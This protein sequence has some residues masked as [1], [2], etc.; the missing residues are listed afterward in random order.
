MAKN[1]MTNARVNG[2]AY[3]LMAVRTVIVDLGKV[4]TLSA[5]SNFNSSFEPF[6][7][8]FDWG[9]NGFLNKVVGLY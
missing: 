5:N 8:V 3:Y 9:V 7:K 2:C 1:M 4:R 6:F